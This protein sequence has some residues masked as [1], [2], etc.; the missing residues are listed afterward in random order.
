[1][2]HS[3]A[4]RDTGTLP[5]SG[6]ASSA[7][8]QCHVNPLGL[9]IAASCARYSG[10]FRREHVVRV[11]LVGSP[12]ISSAV[13]GLG[14][15]VLFDARC[16]P[17]GMRPAAN[18]S[19]GLKRT[20]TEKFG[21]DKADLGTVIGFRTQLSVSCHAAEYLQFACLLFVYYVFFP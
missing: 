12:D 16:S 5:V 6:L 3:L 1:M 4:K 7:F 2:T 13:Q 11:R 17:I 9:S 10:S 14:A 18:H 15:F 19:L 8:I 21:S 20:V